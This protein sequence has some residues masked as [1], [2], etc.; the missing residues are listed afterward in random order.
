[1]G[2]YRRRLGRP[3]RVSVHVAMRRVLDEHQRAIKLRDTIDER[4]VRVAERSDVRHVEHEDLQ[5]DRRQRDEAEAQRFPAD[6][7][8]DKDGEDRS[9]AHREN[10]NRSEKQVRE[11]GRVEAHQRHDCER[12]PRIES[13]ARSNVPGNERSNRQADAGKPAE[14]IEPASWKPEELDIVVDLAEKG[15]PEKLV[16]LIEHDVVWNEVVRVSPRFP[17]LRQTRD[18]GDGGCEKRAR[19]PRQVAVEE[20]FEDEKE[21]GVEQ[22]PRVNVVEEYECGEEKRSTPARAAGGRPAG[23]EREHRARDASERIRV[24]AAQQEIRETGG[25]DGRQPRRDV[26]RICVLARGQNRKLAG[27][28]PGRCQPPF[29]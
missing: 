22:E 12:D 20:R 29:R 5:V 24:A 11:L 6:E 1:M 13:R 25:G 17:V 19:E 9:E 23:S 21:R 16:R 4:G 26:R 8:R 14:V 15:Q 18:D 3:R 2:R 7:S 27:T 10:M 28:F